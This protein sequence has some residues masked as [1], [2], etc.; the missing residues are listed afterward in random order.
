M[1]IIG[2][3]VGLIGI[4]TY[5]RLAGI[6]QKVYSF[7]EVR[8]LLRASGSTSQEFVERFYTG[9]PV[10]SGYVQQ[11]QTDQIGRDLGQALKAL[12]GNPEHP[13][14]YYL[15]MRFS[16]RSHLAAASRWVAAGFSLLLLPAVYWLCVEL[17]YKEAGGQF[18][19]AMGWSAIAVISISPFQ[20]LL[21]HEA[22]QYTL[23]AL[24]TVVSSAF[25][26]RSLRQ[27]HYLHG[28]NS[29]SSQ[30]TSQNNSDLRNWKL[31][32][33]YAG[34]ALLGMYT[35]LFFA[36]TLMAHGLYVV[37]TERF[38]PTQRLLRYLLMSAG[39]VVGFLPWVWVVVSRSDKLS[40]TTRWASTFD[41]G[42]IGR[43]QHW[44]YNL[45]IGFIDFDWPIKWNNPFS[46]LI[47]VA[48][49]ASTWQLCR[50]APKRVWLFVVL[51]IS[52]ST[53]GQI[54]PDLLNG[55]RRS[56]VARYSLTAYLGLELA[57]AYA[58]ARLFI[59]DIASPIRNSLDPPRGRMRG[60]F[61]NLQR[62][63]V[64][65]L[66]LGGA[67]SSLL[68]TQSLGWGKGT[69]G[70][71]AKTAAIINQTEQPLIL[72]D[73]DHP[74]PLSLSHK[75]TP[76]ARFVLINRDAAVITPAV[77]LTDAIAQLPEGQ[78]FFIFAASKPLVASMDADP[79]VTVEVQSK[80]MRQAQLYSAQHSLPPSSIAD[81]AVGSER[82]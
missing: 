30:S 2:L 3:M 50:H 6:G 71:I 40:Q 64:L 23:W 74:Y 10:T 73:A 66:L 76:D 79:T 60:N 55:G 27:N 77:K 11:Y 29:Q 25:L 15:L 12:A 37:L 31:W 33:A 58:I 75:I 18:G 21:A 63:A 45:G 59:P 13:P 4:G 56:I 82:L 41:I 28:Q 62:L 35:H 38:R 53:V 19:R 68:I 14:L 48:V 17:F 22:R 61:I 24:L 46:Y 81:R 26:L 65:S 80:Q 20:V 52:V 70:V 49:A 42:L 44:L 43:S 9:V 8:G 36:W 69:S 78:Q 72:T 1:L 16:L 34:T 32:L 5:G 51:L 39:V 67:L 57:V 47:L 54:L 7:D